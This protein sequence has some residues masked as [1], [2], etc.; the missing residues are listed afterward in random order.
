MSDTREHILHTSFKLFLQKNFKEVT[1]KEIVEH[2]G[3]SK[4]AFYHYF[5]S[6]E[7]V[8]EEVLN[9]F[10]ADF[11]QLNFES[12]SHNSLKEFC[13]D[14]VKDMERKFKSA[15]KLTDEKEAVFTINH[16]FLIFDGMKMLPSYKEKLL[17]HNQEELKSWKKI[18][19]IA[20]KN[21]E[22]K[23][24]MTDEYIAKL[25]IYI[26]DGFGINKIMNETLNHFDTQ[27]HEIIA[28]WKG[29]YELLTK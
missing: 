26:S 17:A 29:L 25:F 10:F 16:Y 9:H 21:G 20:R 15:A 18:V 24:T 28:L 19:R 14:Y 4:G 8:F 5:T 12:Y 3:L 23:A 1:M 7:Q 27:K 22:I 6:K 2:T 13:D 11:M